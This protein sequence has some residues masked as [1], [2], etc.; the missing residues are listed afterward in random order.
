MRVMSSDGE[1]AIEAVRPTA[2]NLLTVKQAQ[3]T[4][5][6]NRFRLFLDMYANVFI[7]QEAGLWWGR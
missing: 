3:L 6:Q 4:E 2:R 1:S 5:M 7:R